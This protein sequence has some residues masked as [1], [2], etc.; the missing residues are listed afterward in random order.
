VRFFVHHWGPPE[1]NRVFGVIKKAMALR[2]DNTDF[3][4][5]AASADATFLCIDGYF[6][7]PEALRWRAEARERKLGPTYAYCNSDAPLSVFPGLY[8]SLSRR[9]AVP[10]YAVGSCYIEEIRADRPAPLPTHAQRQHLWSFLGRTE[11]HPIRAQLARAAEHWAHGY[12]RASKSGDSLGFEAYNDALRQTRFALCPRGF[13]PAS[14]R[15]FEAMQAG[16]VPVIISDQWCAPVGIEW[17]QCS[18]R[19]KESQIDQLPAMLERYADQSDQLG[20]AARRA[21]ELHFSPNGILGSLHQ[22]LTGLKITPRS[23]LL[24]LSLNG[25]ERYHWRA[26]ATT[27]INHFRHRGQTG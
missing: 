26:S 27:L 15:I 9:A 17:D 4:F 19:L 6:G 8:P 14:I 20:A 7:P 23:T 13:G 16:C 10:S 21:W 22:A 1:H 5:D 3:T 11:T 18:L 2:A 25:L 24:S 12:F